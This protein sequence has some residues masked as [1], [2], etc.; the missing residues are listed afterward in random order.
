MA[1]RAASKAGWLVGWL[2]ARHNSN[3]T[4]DT[5]KTVSLQSQHE[6]KQ[7]LRKT[8]VGRK[9]LLKDAGTMGERL[10]SVLA[11]QT[12]SSMFS[13]LWLLFQLWFPQKKRKEEEESEKVSGRPGSCWPPGLKRCPPY[14]TKQ[15][16]LPA[17]ASI[18]PPNTAHVLE[19]AAPIVHKNHSTAVSKPQA[20]LRH[21][22]SHL[23][24]LHPEAWWRC[25]EW[26]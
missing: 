7:Q 9:A 11:Y 8:A 5:A 14:P 10:L 22:S 17:N 26:G 19:L 4:E 16:W 18:S 2:G 1:T 6:E 15:G 21:F 24:D 3:L 23:Q 20:E 12:I 25:G 13:L